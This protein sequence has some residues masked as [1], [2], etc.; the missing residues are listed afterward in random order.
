MVDRNSTWIHPR[1]MARDRF[2]NDVDM[3]DLTMREAFNAAE[4]TSYTMHEEREEQ[5]KLYVEGR[6]E[7]AEA[8]AREVV[9]EEAEPAGGRGTG[10]LGARG[11]SGGDGGGGGGEGEG[12]GL[13]QHRHGGGIP[14]EKPVGT[15]PQ[16]R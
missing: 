12:Q 8:A 14:V 9:E 16:Q 7:E 3:T 15:H 1:E 6:G 4:T 11:G 2:P 10:Q 5:Y 13:P